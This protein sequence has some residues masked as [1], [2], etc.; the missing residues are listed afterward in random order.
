MFDKDDKK[1]DNQEFGMFNFMNDESNKD[2]ED[3]NELTDW[4]QEEIKK[5]NYDPWD[6]EED[7]VDDDSF[8][9]E[10]DN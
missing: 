2:N 4:Q 3:N 8:Y 7:D 10:D 5:G 6:F 1:K 9:S